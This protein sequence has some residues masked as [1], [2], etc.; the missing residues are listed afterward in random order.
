[1]IRGLEICD[2]TVLPSER[3][4]HTH[5]HIFLSSI[6]ADISQDIRTSDR[7]GVDRHKLSGVIRR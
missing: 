2:L 4:A 1:M 6:G 5:E 7:I 3:L